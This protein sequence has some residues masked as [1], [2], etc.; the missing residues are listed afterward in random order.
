MTTHRCAA[1]MRALVAGTDDTICPGCVARLCAVLAELPRQL[2][3]LEELLY[4]SG[5]PAQRG[6]VG[7]AH[8]PL[9]VRL[10]ILDLLGPGH[11]VPRQ[12]VPGDQAEGV[13]IAPLLHGWARYVA[14]S[15]PRVHHDQHGTAHVTRGDA[16]P[17]SRRGTDVPSWC[18]WLLAYAPYVAMQDWAADMLEQLE[19]LLARIR[20]KTDGGPARTTRDAPCPVCTGF[21]LASRDG[22]PVI[23]CE[24]CGTSLTEAEYAQ[25]AAAV[26]PALTHLAVRLVLADRSEAGERRVPA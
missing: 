24:A 13:P 17:V 21:A 16:E 3:L 1:C 4:P 20:A 2:P 22:Q 10:D 14:Q 7:R 26:L 8:S 25:H 11:V 9:P 23:L 19:Q 5:G 18:A 6:S 12:D 15:Y